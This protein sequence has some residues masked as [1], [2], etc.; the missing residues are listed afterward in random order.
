MQR[1][2]VAENGILRL[3]ERVGRALERI[4][5]VVQAARIEADRERGVRVE[6]AAR[7]QGAIR[8]RAR[9]RTDHPRSGHRETADF[10]QH[11]ERDAVDRVARFELELAGTDEATGAE[12]D[13]EPARGAG[14]KLQSYRRGVGVRAQRRGALCAHGHIGGSRDRHSPA[15]QHADL[16]HHARSSIG[17]ELQFAGGPREAR[18]QSGHMHRDAVPPFVVPGVRHRNAQVMRPGGKRYR[19]EVE[20]AIDARARG[21]ETRR[22]IVENHRL[23]G[24][25][26][27][28]HVN[29]IARE[30]A[31]VAG[32]EDLDAGTLNG[33]GEPVGRPCFGSRPRPRVEHP[34]HCAEHEEERL[35]AKAVR[36]RHGAPGA[37]DAA[38]GGSRS[39]S[40]A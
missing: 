40:R 29:V 35:E 34:R 33:R 27:H 17:H 31:P 21:I 3:G 16:E 23:V 37:G 36:A 11:L 26:L 7:R 10:R 8:I 5:A 28:A 24:L 22:A 15:V 39:T 9:S 4:A 25:A 18:G 19:D 1:A 2:G 14:Q 6:P 12:L 30:H 38:R 20:D 32:R 13:D